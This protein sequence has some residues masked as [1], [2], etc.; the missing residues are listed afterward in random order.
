MTYYEQLKELL[1]QHIV[2][3]GV[4]RKIMRLIAKM[5]TEQ[6]RQLLDDSD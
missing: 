4:R 3:E 6:T 5:L 1:E 2:S